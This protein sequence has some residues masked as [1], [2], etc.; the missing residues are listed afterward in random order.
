MA[1]DPA[2]VNG[3]RELQQVTT[4]EQDRAIERAEAEAIAGK[5]HLEFVDLADHE[6]D[7]DLF[8]AVPVD[9]MFRYNFVPL[10]RTEDGR[11]SVHS[12]ASDSVACQ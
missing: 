9:L 8:R 12:M 1:T 3:E 11:L 10:S 2:I 4:T 5:Y 6:V 7:P